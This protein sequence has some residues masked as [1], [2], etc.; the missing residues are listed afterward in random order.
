MTSKTRPHL[1]AARIGVLTQGTVFNCATAFRYPEKKVFGV[2]ITARCDVAQSK[3]RLLN[4]VPCVSLEDWF[5]VDGLEILKEREIDD[6]KNTIKSVLERAKISLS[7]IDSVPLEA[8]AEKNFPA[9]DRSLD[10]PKNTLSACGKR[11]SEV[12]QLEN[13]PT[14]LFDWFK[15]NSQK[16][17]RAIV[18]ELFNHK[19]L[20]YYFLERINTSDE[21]A[22]YVCLLREATSLSKEISTSLAGGISRA[23]WEGLAKFGQAANLD[24]CQEDFACPISQIGSP[25]IEHLMQSFSNLFVRIGLS[26]PK[27]EDIEQL[28]SRMTNLDG[29]LK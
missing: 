9:H 16:S 4:Y 25:S 6:A 8:I 26:D 3:Y 24:F 13:R 20:G 1:E 29:D 5:I 15:K 17:I 19:I 10:K 11:L 21:L 22:G 2:T 12:Q 28:T 7:L 18:K 14:E 23:Q 27:K